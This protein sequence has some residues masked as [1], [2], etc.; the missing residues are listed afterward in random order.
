MNQDTSDSIDY[1]KQV[2]SQKKSIFTSVIKHYSS[3]ASP[4]CFLSNE[5]IAKFIYNK[6]S[7]Q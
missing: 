5:K 4:K 1:V 7:F 2:I 6:N 3:Q